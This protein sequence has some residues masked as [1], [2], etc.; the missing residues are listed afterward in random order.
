M[1]V[2]PQAALLALLRVPVGSP[3]SAPDLSASGRFQNELLAFHRQ[4]SVSSQPSTQLVSSARPSVFIPDTGAAAAGQ[5][6]TSKRGG[7]KKS[8]KKNNGSIRT[9][10]FLPQGK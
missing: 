4:E 1:Q 3:P 10:T 8:P 2:N 6:T 7:E 9:S 5:S